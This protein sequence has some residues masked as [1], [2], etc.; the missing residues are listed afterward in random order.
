MKL[1]VVNCMGLQPGRILTDIA[2]NPDL[3]LDIN[4]GVYSGI[5]RPKLAH[6]EHT[7][8]EIPAIVDC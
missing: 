2:Y 7:I 8:W 4:P 3:I 6:N 1:Y 5:G